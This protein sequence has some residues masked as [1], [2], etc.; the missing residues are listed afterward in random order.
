MHIFTNFCVKVGKN[1]HLQNHA[2]FFKMKILPVFQK[3][4]TMMQ[5][6]A[7]IKPSLNLLNASDDKELNSPLNLAGLTLADHTQKNILALLS[8]FL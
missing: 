8:I 1:V 5:Y 7:S 6:E 2:H 4:T 3:F